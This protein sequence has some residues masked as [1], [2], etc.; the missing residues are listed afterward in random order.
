[1]FGVMVSRKAFNGFL[2]FL[3]TFPTFS[4]VVLWEIYSYGIQPYFGYSNQEV[5]N[6]V[7]ARQLLSCPEACPSAV[8]SLMVE[9]WHEQSVRRPNF[10]EI[11]H[12]LKVWY[13]SQ[14]RRKLR[15]E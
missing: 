10:A 9:C 3:N 14:K 12:R 8:Y 15:F 2:S 6:M 4:G 5:I 11:V 7:R 1:M 13:Q